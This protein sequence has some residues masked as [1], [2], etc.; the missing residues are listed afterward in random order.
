MLGLATVLTEQGMEGIVP[1]VVPAPVRPQTVEPEVVAS[2]DEVAKPRMGAWI[3]GGGIVA[4]LLVSALG[5]WI[6][7]MQAAPARHRAAV[8]QPI[9]GLPDPPA[10]VQEEATLSLQSDAAPASAP[11]ASVP[12]PAAFQAAAPSGLRSP[13]K[14]AARTAPESVF[15]LNPEW[16]SQVRRIGDVGP[17]TE[18]STMVVLDAIHDV[19]E[20]ER[21]QRAAIPKEGRSEP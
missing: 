12:Q 13:A 14:V 18:R 3:L 19:Q 7:Q 5:Y 15:V 17:V 2:D 20:R 11:Q 6:S 9:Q 1:F 21:Q 4:V 10:G 8:T 16:S